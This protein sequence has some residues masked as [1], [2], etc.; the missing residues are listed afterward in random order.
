MLYIP[1][2][3]DLNVVSLDLQAHGSEE[4]MYAVFY[5]VIVNPFA[6]LVL[7]FNWD[8][9]RPLGVSCRCSCNCYRIC[10]SDTNAGIV[11]GSSHRLCVLLILVRGG[12][13][14]V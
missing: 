12:L 8:S 7:L 6:S 14:I 2:A 11:S 4:V 13:S 5:S 1:C 10:S 3:I 9:W